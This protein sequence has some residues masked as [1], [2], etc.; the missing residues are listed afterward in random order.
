MPSASRWALA[1][2]AS[3]P[4][5]RRETRPARSCRGSDGRAGPGPRARAL[6]QGSQV[7]VVRSRPLG[8]L[9]VVERRHAGGLGRQR[10]VERPAHAVHH[11][12]DPGRRGQPAEPQRREAVELGEGAHRDRVGGR[13]GRAPGRCRSRRP[14]H[15][16]RRPRRSP[17]SHRRAAPRA[18]ARSSAAGQVAA[19]RVVRVGEE[20][21]PGA[22]GDLRE[23]R[24]DIGLERRARAPPPDG[25]P[26]PARPA[27]TSG[28]RGGCRAPR[29]PVRHR[30]GPAGRSARPSRRRRRSRSGIEIVAPARSPGA[31]AAQPP[32]G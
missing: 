4:A 13:A 17:G 10:D 24:V 11:V 18:G 15:T 21:Q 2:A 31:A 28:S 32:S 27:G 3:R 14:R 30:R 25:R 19:G 22:R 7:R 5:P 20:D 16:R 26:P 9:L 23:Q 6:S 1:A 29:R 8:M 12:D